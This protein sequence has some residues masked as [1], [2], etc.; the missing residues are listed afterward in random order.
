MHAGTEVEAQPVDVVRHM[1]EATQIHLVRHIGGAAILGEHAGRIAQRLR[2]ALRRLILHLLGRHH[3][4]RGERAQ[5]G[6]VGLGAGAALAGHAAGDRPFATLAGQDHRVEQVVLF[7]QGPASAAS[8]AV[9]SARRMARRAEMVRM[10][11]RQWPT[12]F[13]GGRVHI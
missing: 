12:G 11:P 4:D 6:R 5:D 2:H 1:A 10:I 3:V 9:E 8:M 13:G 7:S